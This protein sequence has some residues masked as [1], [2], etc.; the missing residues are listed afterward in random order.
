VTT[1]FAVVGGVRLRVR[2]AGD[3]RP[4]LIMNNT[5]RARQVIP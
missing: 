3:C 1:R 5:S 2:T 4:L